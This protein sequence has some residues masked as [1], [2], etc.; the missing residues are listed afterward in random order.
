MEV[1]GD[2]QMLVLSARLGTTLVQMIHDYQTQGYYLAHREH[3]KLV[4]YEF[5]SADLSEATFAFHNYR[6]TVAPD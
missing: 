2:T 6:K 5:L 4:N 1:A 3:G